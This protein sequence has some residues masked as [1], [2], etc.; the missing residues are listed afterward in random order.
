M[1]SSRDYQ[2]DKQ[3]GSISHKSAVNLSVG[4][5][6]LV[7]RATDRS[8]SAFHSEIQIVLDVFDESEPVLDWP[9][10]DKN[11]YSGLVKER[12]L[13]SQEITRVNART[14]EGAE[15]WYSLNLVDAT[16][17]GYFSVSSYGVLSTVDSRELIYSEQQ[18]HNIMVTATNAYNSSLT[19]DV[20]V[21]IFV[22]Q[23]FGPQFLPVPTILVK[24]N[25]ALGGTIANI[26]AASQTGSHVMY[27]LIPPNFNTFVIDQ[28]SGNLYTS[29]SPLD[30]RD[31]ILTAEATDLSIGSLT[32][33]LEF[34]V[35]VYDEV[36]DIPVFSEE[37]Y[38][39]SIAGTS[40]AKQQVITVKAETSGTGVLYSI[41][42]NPSQHLFTIDENTGVVMTSQSLPH[43]D[44]HEIIVM[45]TNKDN[46]E[47]TSIA[48]VSVFV[49]E[50]VLSSRKLP[51]FAPVPDPIRLPVSW[52]AGSTFYSV[53]A[54]GAG[55]LVYH[56]EGTNN[57][58]QV[59]VGHTLKITFTYIV[60]CYYKIIN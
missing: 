51:E 50:M 35:N 41:L 52:L 3:L 59:R 38:I 40:L 53:Y 20:L 37:R 43:R 7:I 44:P 34:K 27:S 56:I 4:K 2:I 1:H 21:I 30:V 48:V 5:V 32:S 15:V 45:A 19:T 10:F 25:H 14:L 16:S 29:T 8:D 18:I 46:P 47:Y 33:R 58:F 55:S 12:M 28:I 54:I 49:T 11:F 24:N 57:L 17:E 23:N 13:N 42:T 31:Y 36:E 60:P 6:R 9:V 26:R 22:E 39:A